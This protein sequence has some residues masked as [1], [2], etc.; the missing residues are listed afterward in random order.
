[1]DINIMDLY[2][3]G[4]QVD[5]TEKEV[6]ESG[7]VGNL[8]A[9]NTGVI[10]SAGNVLG[11]CQRKTWL[12]QLGIPSDSHSL[13]RLLMFSAGF[14]SE[15][16]WYDRLAK[17]WPGTILREEE[18]PIEW[19]TS[20]GTKVTGRPDMVLCMP[21]IGEST[22]PQ[23]G[24]SEELSEDHS[25]KLVLEL[26]NVSSLWTARSVLFEGVPKFD[27]L[28][29]AGHYSWQLGVPAKLCYSLY[30]DMPVMG[31]ASK[32]FP[33]QGD[34]YSEYCEYSEPKKGRSSGEIKKVKPFLRIYDLKWT[35][36]GQLLYRIEGSKGLDSWT[37]SPI[38]IS[39]IQKYYETVAELGGP[40]QEYQVRELP[41][42]PL[43][44]KGNG[45]AENWSQCGYCPLAEI[46]DRYENSPG[47][48]VEAVRELRWED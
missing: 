23:D 1:M 13:D 10:D 31:W 7:K 16:I 45:E 20:N 43:T 40:G 3:T 6:S 21:S 42:R 24:T 11:K 35:P 44:V 38:T 26:K 41:P 25:P 8:R 18:T 34:K 30:L 37:V 46:C 12:R 15:D 4:M 14:A 17:G 19:F 39:G 5:E 27:H 2:L 32:L 47:K 48:W 29:Q 33:Q 36:N 22:A 9:G 28:A